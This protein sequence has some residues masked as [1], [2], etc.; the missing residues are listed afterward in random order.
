MVHNE[1]PAL[2]NWKDSTKVEK[3]KNEVILPKEKKIPVKN[4]TIDK[5]SNTE[6]QLTW[7][8]LEDIWV[9]RSEGLK[10]AKEVLW[11]SDPL[12]FKNFELKIKD[13]QKNH[14]IWI[15]GKIWKETFIEMKAGEVLSQAQKKWEE[16]WIY[17]DTQKD[18]L[19]VLK[20][21]NPKWINI[22]WNDGMIKFLTTFRKKFK[23]EPSYKEFFASIDKAILWNTYKKEIE[24]EVNTPNKNWETIYEWVKDIVLDDNLSSKEKTKAIY[25]KY[26][27]WAIL[28]VWIAFLFWAFWSNTK[29]TNTWWKRALVMFGISHIWWGKMLDDIVDFWLEEGNWSESIAVMGASWSN[30]ITNKLREWTWN[31]EAIKWLDRLEEKLKLKNI[32]AEKLEDKKLHSLLWV[33]AWSKKLLEMKVTEL[34]WVNKLPSVWFLS[35]SENKTLKDNWVKTEDLLKFTKLLQEVRDNTNDNQTLSDL[36]ESHIPEKTKVEKSIDK[37]DKINVSDFT[38]IA[39]VDKQIEELDKEKEELK[40]DTSISTGDLAKYT[41]EYDKIKLK[42][43]KKGAEIEENKWVDWKYTKKLEE[44]NLLKDVIDSKEDIEENNIK[45]DELL[46]EIDEFDWVAPKEQLDFYTKKLKEIQK[47]VWKNT[48]ELTKFKEISDNDEIEKLTEKY[49]EHYTKIK[50]I[51]TGK[52]KTSLSS[53]FTNIKAKETEIASLALWNLWDIPE[54]KKF[55]DDRKGESNEYPKLAKELWIESEEIK[56]KDVLV[57]LKE[58]KRELLNKKLSELPEAIKRLEYLR[59][60]LNKSVVEEV[61]LIWKI[62]VLIKSDSKIEMVIDQLKKSLDKPNLSDATIKRFNAFLYKYFNNLK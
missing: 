46:K 35:D 14:K 34:Q 20:N 52:L 9:S 24:K 41:K 4:E 25:D 42:L 21:A 38:T 8:N 26:K 2:L 53:Y 43:I 10:M 33:F 49:K 36:I 60:K 45:I 6:M 18:I 29:M 40:A 31:K 23:S 62:N 13:Y 3:E 44:Y 7:K 37:I 51:S 1:I 28:L 19:W 15:D 50:E 22:S 11:I 57:K 55:L 27:W 47:L 56:T 17:E 48:E 32:W 5:L 39:L 16:E 59:A 54:I 30:S 61:E 12:D 58:K